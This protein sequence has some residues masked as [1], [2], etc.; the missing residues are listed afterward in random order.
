MT[1]TRS[2][3]WENLPEADKA[4]LQRRSWERANSDKFR[5]DFKE[6]QD[7][8]V[9][10]FGILFV[11]AQEAAMR[12]F[13][14]IFPAFDFANPVTRALHSRLVLCIMNELE[15]RIKLLSPRVEL[16]DKAEQ[17]VQKHVITKK[18]AGGR[19]SKAGKPARTKAKSRPKRV[20]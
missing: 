8:G 5:D 18:R 20:R 7:Y 12:A 19:T 10:H 6:T 3:F 17:P 11:H 14:G 4:L 1:N 2:R 16:D 9:K 15:P 13:G